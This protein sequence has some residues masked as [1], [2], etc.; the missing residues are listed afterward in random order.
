MDSGT[1]IQPIP[2]PLEFPFPQEGDGLS[3]S[4]ATTLPTT[5]TSPNGL[6]GSSPAHHDSPTK[7]ED[8][9][10]I[11][12]PVLAQKKRQT[13]RPARSSSEA[14]EPRRPNN[15]RSATDWRGSK[16]KKRRPDNVNTR[17]ER[18]SD[19][20]A[21]RKF[22]VG[23]D[24]YRTKGRVDKTSGRL[25]ISVNEAANRGYLAKALGASLHHHLDPQKTQDDRS[26]QPR[27]TSTQASGLRRPDLAAK[28]STTLGVPT[29]NDASSIPVLNI[30]IMV[31]GSRGDIQ[32]FLKIGKLLKEDYGHNVR[33]A[34]HPAFKKFVEEDTGL[35]FF[36]VGG[37]T[38]F[39]T[40]N[41]PFLS[42]L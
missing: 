8:A 30:V 11:P 33:I 18:A 28:L 21:Y 29:L 9:A 17:R 40:P 27:K 24:N 14:G 41:R 37:G 36:S 39:R 20:D 16:T 42:G 34:T 5:N 15:T 4:P 13:D 38:Y 10:P 32:P 6:G 19:A 25:N 7:P 1:N 31:I 12:R 2:P 3:T 22:S 35:S 23:N 26:H